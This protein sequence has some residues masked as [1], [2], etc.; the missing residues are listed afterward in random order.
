M[1]LVGDDTW[2]GSKVRC[3]TNIFTLLGSHLHRLLLHVVHVDY[4]LL[5]KFP[6]A[7]HFISKNNNKG[8]TF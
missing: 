1:E 4:Q 8:H 5:Q 6:A 2:A 7:A 3:S